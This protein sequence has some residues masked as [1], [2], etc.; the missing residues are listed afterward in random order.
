MAKKETQAGEDKVATSRTS[1]QCLGCSRGGVTTKIHLSAEGKA[2]PLSLVLTEGQA[3]DSPHLEA[4]LGAVLDGI[5]V[6]RVGRGRPRKRPGKV[7]L[8]R[9]YTG[10]PC[11][12]LLCRRGIKHLIPERDDEKEAR[13]KRGQRGGRPVVFVKA[14]YA[15]RNVVERCILRLKQFR[16][17]A[18]RYEKLA[19][20]FLAIVTLASLIL[21]LR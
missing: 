14:E 8:D 10:K 11:R 12:H 16:R 4:V 5:C 1:S 7:R 13:K 20:C 15:K 18:T 17:V 19:D 21:W 6:R 2:R 3:A 9:G